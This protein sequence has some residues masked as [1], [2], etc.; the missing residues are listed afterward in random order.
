MFRSDPE[1]VWTW[2][3]WRLGVC[4][5][6]EP[7]PAHHA[8]VGLERARDAALLVTVGTSGAT[9]LP[10][11]VVR[12]AVD[13]GAALV[14]VNP[15]GNPFGDLAQRMPRGAAVR[16]EAASRSFVSAGR[17]DDRALGLQRVQ[18]DARR[19]LVRAPDED[20]RA[21]EG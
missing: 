15:E 5:A 11:L 6:A 21:V 1:R 20:V 2:Y 13:V 17:G 19:D 4:R 7:N 16:A 10:S 9:N 3:L 8:L 18:G 14:D 12:T